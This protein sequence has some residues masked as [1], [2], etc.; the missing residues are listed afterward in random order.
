MQSVHVNAYIIRTPRGHYVKTKS[1]E[2]TGYAMFQTANLAEVYILREGLDAYIVKV[3]VAITPS[4]SGRTRRVVAF[5]KTEPKEVSQTSH[6]H[7]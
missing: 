1:R 4:H 6:T 3:R 7:V 2:G 5:P